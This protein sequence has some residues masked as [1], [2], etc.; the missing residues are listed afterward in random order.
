MVLLLLELLL[1]QLLLLEQVLLVLVLNVKLLL[2]MLVLEE[3]LLL[4]LRGERVATRGRVRAV[5]VVR[6]VGGHR[7]VLLVR[8]RSVVW[9]V[10]RGRGRLR[11]GGYTGRRLLV[12]GL[13]RVDRRISL[14]RRPGRRERRRGRRDA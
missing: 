11:R 1:N 4:V 9:R 10:R 2:L 3:L 6:R 5:A 8:R 13:E 7:A 12:E 14:E